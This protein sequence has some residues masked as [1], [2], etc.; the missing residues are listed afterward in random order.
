MTRE[1]ARQMAI[2]IAWSHLGKPYL[3]GGDDPIAGMDCSGAVQEWAYS[4]GALAATVDRTAH[5]LW[6]HYQGVVRPA[7]DTGYLVFWWNRD[8][9]RIRHIELCLN[10]A[11]SIGASGGGSRTRTRADAVR[12]NAYIKIRPIQ[13]RGVIA[14]YVDPF[15]PEAPWAVA[16]TL[17]TTG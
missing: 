2:Q 13:G 4:V 7:P 10:D 6:L 5:G 15:A 16:G 8:R 14:G 12:D 3:W 11:L 9:T 1:D 17:H